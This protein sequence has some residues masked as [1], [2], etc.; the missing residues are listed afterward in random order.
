M[1]KPTQSITT[2][3]GGI[4][5]IGDGA[6][7]DILKLEN[8][9]RSHLY[10]ICLVIKDADI[11]LSEDDD[12]SLKLPSDWIEKLKHNNVNAYVEIF[13][14]E[15]DAINIVE[16]VIKEFPNRTLIIRKIRHLYLIADT[17]RESLSKDGDFVLEQVFKE[18][19]RLVDQGT[20]PPENQMPLEE[21][22]RYIKLVMFYAFTK[23]QLL[24]RV[25]EA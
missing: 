13:N 7:I 9:Q 15:A 20:L 14:Q 19:C 22:E 11:P 24:K 21:K 23:C 4:A 6:D 18:L 12:Y 1:A 2:G 3:S 25:N 17:E 16:N 10:D 5:V 8:F